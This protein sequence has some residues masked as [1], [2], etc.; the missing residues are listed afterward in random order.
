MLRKCSCPGISFFEFDLR[1]PGIIEYM[2]MAHSGHMR[3]TQANHPAAQGEYLFNDRFIASQLDIPDALTAP[4]VTR[5]PR[6]N[7]GKPAIF[8]DIHSL[9][10]RSA[11]IRDLLA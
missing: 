9:A 10:K 6:M 4:V 5:R 3:A 2:G 8:R 11:T 1:K 7:D